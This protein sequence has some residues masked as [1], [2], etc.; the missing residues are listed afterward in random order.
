LIQTR[1]GSRFTLRLLLARFTHLV[2]YFT[3]PAAALGVT[4]APSSAAEAPTDGQR[5]LAYCEEAEKEGTNVNAFR[6][7]YCMAFV[8]GTLRGWEAG[9]YVRD[10]PTN[11]CITPGTTLGQMVRVVTK[12]LREKNPGELRGK[13]EVLVIAAIQKAFPCAARKP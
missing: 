6:A 13:G 3:I 9:A 7:A 8:E 4:I 1:G 10:A 12:S 5:L 11:Y 2:A